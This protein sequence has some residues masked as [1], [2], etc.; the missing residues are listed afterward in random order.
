MCAGNAGCSCQTLEGDM[1]VVAAL[2]LV[3][4]GAVPVRAQA[5]TAP[6]GTTTTLTADPGD[7]TSGVP[8]PAVAPAIHAERSFWQ[9]DNRAI[10]LTGVVLLGQTM[11]IAGLLIQGR[12]RR[13]AEQELRDR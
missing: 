11:L 12:R 7:T 2:V 10:L 8:L 3:L 9:G 6:T 13:K 4:F 5:N 1:T